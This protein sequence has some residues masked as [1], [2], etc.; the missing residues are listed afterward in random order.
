MIAASDIGTGARTVL[1]QIAADALEVGPS[2]VTVAIGDSRLPFA[3]LAGGSMGTTS[4]GTAVLGACQR[5]RELLATGEGTEARFDTADDIKAEESLS[6]HSFGAQFVEVRVDLDSAEVQIA[7]ALGTFGAGQI[8]NPRT[9]RSQ[10]I[11]GMAMGIGMALHEESILDRE[12]GDY[13]NHDFAGYH[14][15]TCADIEN[16]EAIWVQEDDPRIN[17]LGIKGIDEIGIV[18]TA[19]AVA[20]AVHH[21]TGVRVRDLPI[22]PSRLVGRL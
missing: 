12:F 13:L 7:R 3:M 16:L 6:R 1:T 14:I 8:I 22:V 11:G 17:P 21:A 15:P 4:W 5:L 10:F 19:A 2:D 9:A 20:N 18:G